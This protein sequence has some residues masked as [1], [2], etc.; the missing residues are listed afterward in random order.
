MPEDKIDKVSNAL[1]S[2]WRNGGSVNISEDISSEKNKTLFFFLRFNLSIQIFDA[3][4][5]ANAVLP[6]EGLPAIITK[7]DL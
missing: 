1:A 3:I 2:A 5:V 6:I 7:S 4:F